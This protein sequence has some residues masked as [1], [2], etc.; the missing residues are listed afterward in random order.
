MRAPF[1]QVGDPRREPL[2]MQAEPQHIDRRREQRRVDAGE[3]RRTALFDATIVQCRSIASAGYGSCPASTRSI[4]L[5]AASSAGS[6]SA[7]CGNTGAKPGRDQ[8][9]V[10]LAQRHVE[11]LGEPQHHVARRLRP[12]GFEKAEM[13][14]RNL[15]VAGK[16]ELAEAAALTPLAEVMADRL[17]GSHASEDSRTRP[18]RHDL[19]G[20]RRHSRDRVWCVHRQ[21]DPRRWS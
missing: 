14:G 3:Q 12:P 2:G 7:R 9:R 20:N 16:V 18:P 10:A 17:C 6:S 4:A 19:R 13:A 11:L 1:R 8:Q 5:R 21:P 15:G